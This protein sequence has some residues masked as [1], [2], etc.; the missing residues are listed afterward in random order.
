MSP[1]FVLGVAPTLWSRSGE[2]M[3][4]AQE[5]ERRGSMAQEEILVLMESVRC[6]PLVIPLVCNPML[7]SES[8]LY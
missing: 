7:L 8:K 6:A 1:K 3:G 5:E 4:Y 2:N